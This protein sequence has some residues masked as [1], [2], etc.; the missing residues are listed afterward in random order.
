[1]K[2]ISKLVHNTNNWTCI[3]GVAKTGIHVT[4]S[5]RKSYY[6]G[7]E[8][9]NNSEVLK[10]HQFAYLDS[11]RSFPRFDYF[12]KIELIN[13]NQQT[14]YHVGRLKG[15]KQIKC[16]EIPEIK[17]TLLDEN[18][19]EQVQMDFHQIN[20]LREIENNIE[21]MSCWKSEEIVAPINEGF[22]LNVRYDEMTF[23]DNAIDLSALNPEI[24]NLKRL[25]LLFELPPQIESILPE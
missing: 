21:Y 9:W 24:N 19:L 13:Y 15:V 1:M 4:N 16:N 20:D 14:V 8:E 25:V 17:K 2:K 11:F 23:F 12:E 7:L 18:W 10:K 22:I 3:A 6:F 5:E